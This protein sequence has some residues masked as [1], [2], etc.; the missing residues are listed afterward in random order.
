MLKLNEYKLKKEHMQK[1]IEIT[2]KTID[3]IKS[4]RNERKLDKQSL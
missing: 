2:L 3:A 4:R 1:Q